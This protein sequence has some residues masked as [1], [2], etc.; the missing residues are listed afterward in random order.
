MKLKIVQAGYENFTGEMG[1]IEFKDGVS[2]LDVHPDF[3]RAIGTIVQ[4]EQVVEAVEAVE[5]TEEADEE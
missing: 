1:H 2:V 5:Q 3:A 4:V